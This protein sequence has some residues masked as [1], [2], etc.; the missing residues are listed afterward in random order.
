MHIN[1]LLSKAQLAYCI[2]EHSFINVYQNDDYLWLS[3]NDTIQS[4]MVRGNSQ[5]LT[6]PHQLQLIYP[7][8]LFTPNSVLICGL[9]G[10][11]LCRY[12][13]HQLP[14]AKLT[15]IDY[16]ETV[17]AIFEQFFNPEKIHFNIINAD[18]HQWL[19]QSQHETFD[20]II[21][22]IFSNSYD[23][24]SQEQQAI[25]NLYSAL[26]QGGWLSFNL[27]STDIK[28]ATWLEQTLN[29]QFGYVIK[30]GNI[31]GF[32]NTIFHAFKTI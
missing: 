23:N 6:L 12:L 13:H 28:L 8:S 1:K 22:D 18:I 30:V 24:I 9:G 10:G 29:N 14:L 31:A 20:W 27:T 26:S 17:I 3:F 2:K 32:S 19:S 16:S 7:L 15:A 4:I 25:D 21:Y 5:Q 11:D